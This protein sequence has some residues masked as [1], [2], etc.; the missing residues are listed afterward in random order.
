M[1]IFSL[2][3]FKNIHIQIKKNNRQLDGNQATEKVV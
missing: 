1:W 2:R 3:G